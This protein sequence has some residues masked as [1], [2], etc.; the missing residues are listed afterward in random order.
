MPFWRRTVSSRTWKRPESAWSKQ[1]KARAKCVL[2]GKGHAFARGRALLHASVSLERC[3]RVAA[4]DLEAICPA[5]TCTWFYRESRKKR[6]CA[7]TCVCLAVYGC[8]K[9]LAWRMMMG[10]VIDVP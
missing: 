6:P 2:C 7:C 9:G 3:T 4:N 1:K 10:G 5:C 8:E